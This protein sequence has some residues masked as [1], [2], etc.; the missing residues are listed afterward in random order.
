MSQV[1]NADVQLNVFD[2]M[3]GA[4]ELFRLIIKACDIYTRIK[5]TIY[6][7][8]PPNVQT[9]LDGLTVACEFANSVRKVYRN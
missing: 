4:Q 2:G 6:P 8:L 3:R 9:V 7:H 5:P 1:D